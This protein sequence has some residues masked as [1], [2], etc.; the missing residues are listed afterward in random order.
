MAGR[1]SE[2]DGHPVMETRAGQ[3]CAP[4][5]PQLC[6]LTWGQGGAPYLPL[7]TPGVNMQGDHQTQLWHSSFLRGGDQTHGRVHD[8]EGRSH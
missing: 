2:Q 8:Q 1:G 3:S 6:F 4:P 5:H 7:K